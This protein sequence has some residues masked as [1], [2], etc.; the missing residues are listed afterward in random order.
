MKVTE[1][2]PLYEPEGLAGGLP[3]IR[4]PPI[5]TWVLAGGTAVVINGDVRF[6]ASKCNVIEPPLLPVSGTSG[7]LRI[8]MTVPG[9][10]SISNIAGENENPMLASTRSPVAE[11]EPFAYSITVPPV[12]P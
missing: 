1:N 11:R 9:S 8:V 3:T 5:S 7:P 2:V 4:V 10:A 6:A 12:I